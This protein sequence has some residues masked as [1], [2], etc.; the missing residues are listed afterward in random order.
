MA[1]EIPSD[2]NPALMGLAW[3]RGRWEGT[4]YREWPGEEKTEFGIQL[5]IADNGDDYL[6]YLAQMFEIDDQGRP[7]KP[8]M[9]ETGFWR[10]N[11]HAE[12]E[13]VMCSPEGFADVWYG[14][15][16]PGRVD[17]VT[18][19]VARTPHATVNYTAG[20]RLYG[21]VDGK[22][23]YSFDRA[24]DDVAL[25]PYVWATLERR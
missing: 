23:M 13:A 19:V 9:I 1:F 5:D 24:T 2:L 14:T 11:D 15:L 7:V 17:I 20:R 12:V 16:Q 8:L 25:R 3:L 10:A 4:G 18:D 21:N 6:H 22:L